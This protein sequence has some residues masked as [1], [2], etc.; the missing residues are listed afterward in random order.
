MTLAEFKTQMLLLGWSIQPESIPKSFRC[1]KDD[2]VIVW[3]NNKHG[4]FTFRFHCNRTGHGGEI[5]TPNRMLDRVK[6]GFE[7]I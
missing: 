6:N 4:R 7:P 3:R 2:A 1:N 5:Y